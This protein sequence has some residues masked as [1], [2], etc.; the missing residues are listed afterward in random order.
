MSEHQYVKKWQ[1]LM[2][3]VLF[4][5]GIIILSPP[6]SAAD[7]T[8]SKES[9]AAFDSEK[10]E[11]KLDQFVAWFF[12]NYS[13]R[14][15]KGI[16]LTSAPQM[17]KNLKLSFHRHFPRENSATLMGLFLRF[18]L[19]TPELTRSITLEVDRGKV[20]APEVFGLMSLAL[21]LYEAE[22]S[23]DADGRII[24]AIGKNGVIYN[25]KYRANG[26]YVVSIDKAGIK[27]ERYIDNAG[28]LRHIKETN[29]SIF[30]NY[31]YGHG[32][33]IATI[34]VTVHDEK[35][36][37]EYVFNQ[38]WQLRKVTQNGKSMPILEDIFKAK[39]FTEIASSFSA[40][41]V[42]R[43]SA[44]QNKLD[45]RRPK[46]K[47]V[48]TSRA[49][50]TFDNHFFDFQ[51]NP[52]ALR[53]NKN[54]KTISYIDQILAISGIT[55]PAQSNV[56]IAAIP[57]QKMVEKQHNELGEL[58]QTN[59]YLGGRLQKTHY[60][61]GSSTTY[62]YQDNKA[63]AF[64]PI[65]AVHKDKAG[66]KILYEFSNPQQYAMF[67]ELHGNKIFSRSAN[68]KEKQAADKLKKEKKA[69][70]PKPGGVNLAPAFPEPPHEPTRFTPQ[71][72]GLRENLPDFMK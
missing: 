42:I 34:R 1:C 27:K 72:I 67:C 24:Q 53:Y 2:L 70:Q 35:G 52:I 7:P 43:A 62:Y 22:F 4:F 59:E 69:M 47:T 63:H 39:T 26:L 41:V 9:I 49:G 36:K 18:L 31:G 58:V 71:R 66:R 8:S 68:K 3:S 12:R 54:N 6:V 57:L 5:T 16:I 51:G 21:E 28:L 19:K 55:A 20:L 50:R 30:F 45:S 25:F 65:A 29:R 56:D 37:T 14:Q 32:G 40:P 60:P 48:R 33:I 17:M 10:E 44:V 13:L 15:I 61:D 64:T 38:K 46:G 23:T 11:K